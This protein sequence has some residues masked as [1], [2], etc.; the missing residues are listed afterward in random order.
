MS[1]VIPTPLLGHLLVF[2]VYLYL[3]LGFLFNNNKPLH[4][5]IKIKQYT[6]VGV[7]RCGVCLMLFL[8]ILEQGRLSNTT[9]FR[10]L[11]LVPRGIS[12]QILPSIC[13]L[14]FTTF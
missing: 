10:V 3:A 13:F 7:H 8:W 14:L 5:G 4:R 11:S 1:W 12:L 6:M 2:S 9:E